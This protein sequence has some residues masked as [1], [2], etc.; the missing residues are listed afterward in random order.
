M[1]Y[2]SPQLRQYIR[3]LASDPHVLAVAFAY[4]VDTPPLCPLRTYSLAEAPAQFSPQM[5]L[6]L[7]K[8]NTTSLLPS[9]EL[10][11]SLQQHPAPVMLVCVALAL[12]SLRVKAWRVTP[13]D[14]EAVAVTL[15]KPAIESSEVLPKH[16]GLAGVF[17]TVLAM[18]L[19]IIIAVSLLP[20]APSLSPP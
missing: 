15:A 12:G 3:A 4:D 5:R 14:V 10:V 7:Y 1:L 20:A 18:A 13:D 9:A 17:A 11:A 2:L 19:L 6:L 8:M 16:E